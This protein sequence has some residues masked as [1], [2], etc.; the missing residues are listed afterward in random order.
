MLTT[1]LYKQHELT[2]L[3]EVTQSNRRAEAEGNRRNFMANG[4][5]IKGDSE[6]EI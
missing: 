2:T 1:S 6:G 5:Q 3:V 4:M